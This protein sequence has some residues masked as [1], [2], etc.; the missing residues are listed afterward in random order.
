MTNRDRED[1]GRLKREGYGY[2]AI[3]KRLGLSVNT[4]KAYCRRHNEDVV[5]PELPEI[6]RCKQCGKPL[7]MTPGKRKKKFCSD[8]CRMRFWTAHPNELRRNQHHVYTCQHCGR[9]F[10]SNKHLGRKFCSRACAGA[11]RRKQGDTHGL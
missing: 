11:A 4:V 9:E 1:I 7:V 8:A 6:A 2:K 5:E 3:S 10:K